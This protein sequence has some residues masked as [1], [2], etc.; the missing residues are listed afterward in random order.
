MFALDVPFNSEM[1]NP[2][3]LGLCKACA[4]PKQYTVEDIVQLHNRENT[5]NISL[6]RLPPYHPELNPIEPVWGNIKVVT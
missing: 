6:A 5:T 2:E 1:R 3:L 4:P